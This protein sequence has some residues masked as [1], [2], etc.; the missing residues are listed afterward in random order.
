MN[1]VTYVV[2]NDTPLIIVLFN[3]NNNN[4]PQYNN[5]NIEFD[6]SDIKCLMFWALCYQL[7]SNSVEWL[8]ELVVLKYFHMISFFLLSTSQNL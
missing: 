2:I 6:I 5:V 7:Y 1:L 3:N 8:M 4:K